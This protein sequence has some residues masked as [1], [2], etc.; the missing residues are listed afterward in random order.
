M[1]FEVLVSKRAGNELL[2][3]ISYYEEI[4][5]GLGDNLRREV[6]NGLLSLHF[7]PK[8]FAKRK[9]RFR[10]FNLK[11]FPFQIIYLVQE[12]VHVV[13]V[14]SICHSKRKTSFK[15]KRE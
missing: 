2:Q 4:Q 8:R 3:A 11:K 15:F 12:K 1:K 7:N 14:T 10:V 13:L 6:L 9:G 5:H